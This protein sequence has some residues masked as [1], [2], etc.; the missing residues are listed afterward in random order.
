M[1]VDPVALPEFGMS[2]NWAMCR[3]PMCANFGTDLDVEI[4][5]GQTQ[6]SSDRYV[7]KYGVARSGER[8]GIM[9][10]RYC[11]QSSQLASNHAIRPI[12][13]Y[14]LSLSMPFADCPDESCPH[15][16]VNLFEHWADKG[17][18]WRRYYRR[19]KGEHL[20]RCS[21]P[22]CGRAVS[23]GTALG[24]GRTWEARRYWKEIL[25]GLTVRRSVTDTF[26]ETGIPI[27][28][29]YA[30]LGRIGG[31]LR[32]YHS[33]RNAALLRPG[34][35]D[36]GEPVH[37]YTDV[38]EVSLKAYRHDA[39]HAPLSII[40]STLLAD[41]KLFVLAVHPFFLPQKLCPVE[42]DWRADRGRPVC[43]QRWCSVHHRDKAMNPAWDTERRLQE[44]PDVGRF[45]ISS[46]YAEV[47]H[48]LV[49]QKM[50]SRFDAIYSYMDGD[51]ASLAAAVVA[52]RDRI[53]AGDPERQ[54]DRDRR[55][56]R[57]PAG[58]DRA[59]PARQ[60]C[61][62]EGRLVRQHAQVGK[63]A[64][65]SLGRDGKG[66]QEAGDPEGPVAGGFRQQA[67]SACPR[68]LIPERVQGRLL[69]VRWLGLAPLPRRH[70]SLSPLPDPLGD[71][72]AREDPPRTRQPRAVARDAAAGGLDNE[73]HA[74]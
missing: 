7:F 14:F 31:R 65:R 11:G 36:R 34:V 48:F 74:G 33:F 20:A 1:R 61:E 4:P 27:G 35:V 45:F 9:T 70:G 3:N 57:P 53:L 23:L 42:E 24:V 8:T 73:L 28:S 54:V 52:M 49:V 51:K 18:P 56:R 15:H 59:V 55:T 13:R 71:P 30:H 25:H 17:S 2:V 5:P 39:R 44:R 68:R 19:Q 50:L 60:E 67:G 38:L 10:C 41:K 29:Y 6:A 43:L 37:V 72:Y 32:D 16:G 26:E 12:A 64:Q 47:A 62:E 66:V 58:R 21:A 40:V 22:G 69:E 63:G 46:P